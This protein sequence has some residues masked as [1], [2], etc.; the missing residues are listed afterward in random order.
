MM[1]SFEGLKWVLLLLSCAAW[2]GCGGSED[3]TEQPTSTNDDNSDDGTLV[4]ESSGGASN[5][6]DGSYDAAAGASARASEPDEDCVVEPVRFRLELAGD[7]QYCA[8]QGAGELAPWLTLRQGSTIVNREISCNC[9]QCAVLGPMTS[10]EAVLWE[11][12]L[13]E[14]EWTGQSWGTETCEIYGC[15]LAEQPPIQGSC[16]TSS[17]SESGRYSAEMCAL[18]FESGSCSQTERCVTVQFDYPTDEVVVGVLEDE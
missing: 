13:L 1:R 8:P 4:D 3:A 18:V 9:G 14:T 16:A 2:S 11:D 12:G 17:C 5:S 15:E 7:T 6:S 10:W